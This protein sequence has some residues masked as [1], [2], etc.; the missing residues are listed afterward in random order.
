MSARLRGHGR[1]GERI[2]AAA[3]AL[4]LLASSR[5][6]QAQIVNVQPLLTRTQQGG[7]SGAALASLD[8]RSGNTQL[9]LA[10]GSLLASYQRGPRILFF[11]TLQEYGVQGGERFSSRDFEHLRYRHQ[12]REALALEAFVQHDR[13]EFR[14]LALRMV[15]GTGPR[16]SWASGEAL[17]VAAGLAYLLEHERLSEGPQLDSGEARLNHRLSSYVTMRIRLADRLRIG[18]TTY[19]QPRMDEP[20]DLRVLNETELLASIDGTIATKVTFSMGFDSQ[21]PASRRA[22]DLA[23]KTS[24]QFSF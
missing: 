11:H 14:R 21:P 13:D 3:L 12:L 10:S 9:L 23:T 6:S 5:S 7:F 15:A 18:Q 2:V 1:I 16:I 20:N 22:L 17:D 4:A 8:V 19:V 24:L